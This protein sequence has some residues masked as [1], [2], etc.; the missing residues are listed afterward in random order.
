M[1]WHGCVELGKG[2]EVSGE[3]GGECFGGMDSRQWR[4]F[5]PPPWE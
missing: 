2:E 1:T 3:V 5:D 4:I